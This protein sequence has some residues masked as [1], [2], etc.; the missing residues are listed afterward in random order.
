MLLEAWYK[1]EKWLNWTD[2]EFSDSHCTRQ[3]MESS[4]EMFFNAG[5]FSPG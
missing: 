5:I 2:V 4:K 3:V 1:S